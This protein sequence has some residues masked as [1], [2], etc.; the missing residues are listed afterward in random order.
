MKSSNEAKLILREDGS[1]F[2]EGGGA[3]DATYTIKAQ[4][5]G[6]SLTAFRLEALPDP[7]LP[8]HGPGRGKDG[9]AYL[10][11][12]RVTAS[13]VEKKPVAGRFVRVE[14]PGE[15]RM[16][17]LAEVEAFSAGRNV[18]VK[19]RATQSSVDYG[20]GP[21]LAV[22]GRTDGDYTNAKSTLTPPTRRIRGGKWISEAIFRSIGWSSGTGRMAAWLT[23]RR[24]PSEDPRRKPQGGWEFHFRAIAGDHDRAS[25]WHSGEGNCLPQC[26]R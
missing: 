4:S 25:S 17:A 19:G 7:A 1:V 14:L 3:F 20:G 9:K 6:K 22:D 15:G 10:T 16:L 23:P 8:A 18:A 24:C 5:G 12:L 2:A 21:E 11:E 13:S 26:Q